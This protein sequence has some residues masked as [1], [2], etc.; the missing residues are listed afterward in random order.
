MQIMA[1]YA[2]I[3]LIKVD[4]VSHPVQQTYFELREQEIRTCS[5][6]KLGNLG[7]AYYKR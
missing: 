4:G 5:S 6:L 1:N 3:S 7:A 2:G